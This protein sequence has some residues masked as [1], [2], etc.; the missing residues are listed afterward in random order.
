MAKP[1]KR[2]AGTTAPDSPPPVANPAGSSRRL[3]GENPPDADSSSGPAST[4]P[5]QALVQV[6]EIPATALSA[7]AA[8][9]SITWPAEQVHLLQRLDAESG[10][11]TSPD[12]KLYAHV[13]NEGHLLVE[14]LADG[15]YQI[16]FNFT[17]H[18]P[19]PFLVKTERQAIWTFERP[20]WLAHNP[21][22]DQRQTVADL[23]TVHQP[24]YLAPEDA[25]L[26]SPAL[27]TMDGVRYDKHRKTYIDTPD[28]T[29]M[30]RRNTEGHYQQASASARDTSPIVFAQIPG[31]R[32]WRRKTEVSES[33]TEPA[34]PV[35]RK[36]LP[37][38]QEPAPGPSK[39]AHQEDGSD[40]T[41]ALSESLLSAN[42]AAINLSYG[43]WRNWGRNIPPQ[44]DQHIEIDGQ[45]Y[46]I[47][48][49]N[50]GPNPRLVYLLHPLFSP[51]LY[52]AFEYMLRDN[53]AMQPR[54]A[55]K[56]SNQW[57]VLDNVVPFEM[58]ITQYISRTFKYLSDQSVSALARAM[59][60]QANR[61]EVIN[62]HGLALLNQVF[63]YWASRQV[64]YAPRRELSD[65]LLMLR[66][67]EEQS[68]TLT[69]PSSLGEGLMRLD[70][71]PGR[72]SQHWNGYA[73]ARTPP[74][75]RRLFSRVLEDD[76]YEVNATA[77]P[78][79]DDAL[80][81]HRKK[82]DQVF[83][84]RLPPLINGRLK[85]VTLESFEFSDSQLR[86]L[87]TEQKPLSTYREENKIIYLL[88]GVQKDALGQTT[89]FVIRD[90]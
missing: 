2:M 79:G 40:P 27:Q 48:H 15:R 52:D 19:G 35:K 21:D 5:Q 87:I 41:Q 6:T 39:R 29:V 62:G 50:P 43:L 38:S 71:D 73:A 33:L 89:L 55:I 59:F 47:L 76:D 86:T 72:F 7:Q 77:Q 90:K 75:L 23:P 81:F 61:S 14:S 56:R 65:P 36:S 10:L 24:I 44:L 54:W 78:L 34:Q 63:H 70:F 11:F 22:H 4:H 42:P 20:G 1:P 45:Y 9:R 32:L 3:P 85:R 51:D 31:T 26:L 57:R 49:Q 37:D 16:P 12:G 53:P 88:G 68:D 30:V 8:L 74:N 69:I 67:P 28:G 84:L 58:P 80:L 13:E 60:N 46:R 83:V 18:L 17:P 82:I 25:T 64:R 66:R